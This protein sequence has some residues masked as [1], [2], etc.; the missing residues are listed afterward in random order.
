MIMNS[1]KIIL[2]CI[3]CVGLNICE[4]Q[5][6]IS[7][8]SMNHQELLRRMNVRDYD[9]FI[10][11][12]RCRHCYD[13]GD[14]E[15]LYRTSSLYLETNPERYLEVLKDFNITTR[16]M[17]SFL[18][19]LPLSTVDNIDLKKAEINKRINLLL[20]V[21]DSELKNQALEILKNELVFF[22]TIKSLN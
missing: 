8:C 10:E 3:L 22:G 12:V 9:V 19:M 11:F 13:G 14:L 1:P 21:R 17:E 4:A 5:Q 2:L 16:E 15:D 18:L 20:L 7:T 6:P